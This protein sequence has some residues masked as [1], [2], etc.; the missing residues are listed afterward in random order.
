MAPKL[1]L[2]QPHSWEQARCRVE[3]VG[4]SD[5]TDPRPLEASFLLPG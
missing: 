4:Y 1:L 3:W 2:T 5:L